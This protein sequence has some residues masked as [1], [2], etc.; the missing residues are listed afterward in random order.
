MTFY[1]SDT[2]K[3]L[4]QPI[5]FL[6]KKLGFKV[7][8]QQNTGIYSGNSEV[9]LLGV[10]VGTMHLF[11]VPWVCGSVYGLR[12]QL[13]TAVNLPKISPAAVAGA[14]DVFMTL[15]LKQPGSL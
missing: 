4:K 8:M 12:C 14:W 11:A 9:I 10:G 2:L 15:I 6:R 7:E 5:Q 1:S 13:L 3:T